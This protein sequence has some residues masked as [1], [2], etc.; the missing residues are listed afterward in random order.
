MALN[1]ALTPKA[2]SLL[3]PEALSALQK[4]YSKAFP[5]LNLFA[6]VGMLDVT[7]MQDL[8]RAQR[9]IDEPTDVLS[10]PTFSHTDELLQAASER[11]VLMGSIVI[12]P[13]KAE[14]YNETLPQLVH[15]GLLHLFGYDHETDFAAWTREEKR[16]LEILHTF[17]LVIPP[18]S[19]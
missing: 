16:I 19:Q 10:F 4:G 11:P 6:E 9:D 12:C 1:L 14:A 17:D 7:E 15:H 13:D 18:V 5:A 3:D 8:N 2:A